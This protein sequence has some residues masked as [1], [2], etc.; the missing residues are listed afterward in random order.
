MKR[1]ACLL[2]IL[3]AAGAF[4]GEPLPNRG[5]AAAVRTS[6]CAGYG[7]GFVP[8]EGTTTCVKVS[9]YVR[10]E[11]SWN[12]TGFKGH[13]SRPADVAPPAP[14]TTGAILSTGGARGG[15]T[16]T[17]TQG[18]I[19]MD[20]RTPTGLGTARSYLRLRADQFSGAMS[21]DNR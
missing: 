14:A 9:G 3:P 17:L 13:F 7:P 11:Y 18:S 21:S 6:Q 4:A 16:G 12:S 1:L 2:L 15:H 19:T 5:G 10:A 8:V 20:V